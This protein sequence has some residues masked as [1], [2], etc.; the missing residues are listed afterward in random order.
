VWGWIVLRQKELHEVHKQLALLSTMENFVATEQLVVQKHTL[1]HALAKRARQHER[2]V[3]ELRTYRLTTPYKDIA[4]L[5]N[6]TTTTAYSR[7]CYLREQLAR[8]FGTGDL[9]EGA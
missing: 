2:L 9:L 7:I 6:T 3:E 4:R 8:E 5:L 1:E